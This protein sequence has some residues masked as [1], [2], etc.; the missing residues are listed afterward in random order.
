MECI[1]LPQIESITKDIIIFDDEF[2]H[3]K[4][5]HIGVGEQ[6]LASNGNGILS[7][8]TIVN[9]DKK[10]AQAIVNGIDDVS[11]IEQNVKGLALGV[12]DNKDRFEF[13]LEKAVELG[14]TDFYPLFTDFTQ[15]KNVNIDRLVSKSIAAL[16]QSKRHFLT[17]IH[18]ATTLDRFLNSSEEI[19]LYAD[20]S[21]DRAMPL[22]Q[23]NNIIVVGPE[24]GFSEREDNL[25]KNHKSALGFTLGSYRLR[26]ETA[27]VAAISIYNFLLNK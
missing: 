8:L 6:I 18:P 5:L 27:A 26:A 16:K 15:R 22:S 25:L 20:M 14:I 19:I 23:K 9:I 3:L 17:N 13:A 2:K 7:E 1:Y 24:G 12:L 4:A 10:S 21:T 11:G